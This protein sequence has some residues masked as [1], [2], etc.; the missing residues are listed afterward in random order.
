MFLSV[1]V[2]YVVVGHC[3]HNMVTRVNG[4]KVKFGVPAIA[5]KRTVIECISSDRVHSMLAVIPAFS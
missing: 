3:I 2:F 1:L 4:F 5:I